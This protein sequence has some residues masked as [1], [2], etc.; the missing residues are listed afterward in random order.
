[1]AVSLEA[2]LPILDHRLVE[3]AWR[4][5]EAMK[6]RN[7]EGKW[8]LRQLLY[9]YVPRTLIDRPKM[10][11]GVPIGD[12]M[13]GPLLDWAEDLLSESTFKK[14]GLLRAAPVLEKM[15]RSQIGPT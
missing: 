6:I 13:R 4:L 3:F 10:G 7:G 15:A 1:M 2:R 12:W 11:F 9:K 8:L 14:H 5:P